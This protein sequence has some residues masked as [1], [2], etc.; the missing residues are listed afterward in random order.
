MLMPRLGDLLFFPRTLSLESTSCADSGPPV[1]DNGSNDISFRPS[2]GK[3]R[4][5]ADISKLLS[6]GPRA[7]EHSAELF[8]RTRPAVGTEVVVEAE[9][10]CDEASR[11]PKGF[12]PLQMLRARPSQK[13]RKLNTAFTTL[14]VLRGSTFLVLMS[15][16]G[17]LGSG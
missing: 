2:N 5:A 8:K 15:C 9:K 4:P 3:L 7:W 13:L 14:G 10:K 6:A 12:A 11:S 16:P 17:W 1:A